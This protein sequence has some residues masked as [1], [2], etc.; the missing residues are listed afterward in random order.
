MKT[1]FSKSGNPPHNLQIMPLSRQRA[2]I[3]TFSNFCI[4]FWHHLGFSQTQY[5][6]LSSFQT[7]HNKINQ[8]TSK[9]TY[10]SFF[11]RQNA[12]AY[13]NFLRS[14]MAAILDFIITHL[15]TLCYSQAY[16]DENK[17]FKSI[18][19]TYDR[20]VLSLSCLRVNR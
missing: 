20:Q 19:V 14:V 3:L 16:I 15:E 13:G 18:N 6:T 7:K 9:M 11:S 10:K 4:M 1:I 2:K 8:C 5:E 17:L 12:N